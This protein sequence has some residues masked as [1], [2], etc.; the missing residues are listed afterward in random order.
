VVGVWESKKLIKTTQDTMFKEWKEL[1]ANAARVGDSNDEDHFQILTPRY[2]KYF[3]TSQ[4]SKS[5]WHMLQSLTCTEIKF[6]QGYEVVQSRGKYF[7]SLTLE[8][9]KFFQTCQ[10]SQFF[11]HVFQTST[12]GEIKFFQ[13]YEVVQSRANT[14]KALHLDM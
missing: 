12:C 1:V 6:L 4:H 9:A 14:S 5:C 11:R 10:H 7:Q 13:G 2:A 3:Q 8:H